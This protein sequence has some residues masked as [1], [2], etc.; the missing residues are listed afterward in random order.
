MTETRYSP[1]LAFSFLLLLLVVGGL[2]IQ[3]F[4]HVL[5]VNLSRTCLFIA[6]PFCL[7]I[8][9]G[10]CFPLDKRHVAVALILTLLLAV[11]GIASRNWYDF[12]A[13][14]MGYQQPTAEAI[15][16]GWNPF[17]P[18]PNML[19]QQIYPSG[20]GAA[21]ASVAA[22][23]GSIEAAKMLQIWWIVIAL[24]VLLA[25]LASYLGPLSREQEL[26]AALCVFSSI[27]FAQLLTHYVDALV[28]LSGVTFLGAL[29]MYGNWQRGN[30]MPCLAMAASILFLANAK[31]S[32]VY[33]AVAL[34]AT[35]VLFLWVGTKRA[36]WKLAI[37]LFA[38]GLVAVFFIGYRPYVTNFETYGIAMFPDNP[39]A[40][41]GNQR[42]SSF[43]PLPPPGR[44]FYSL[45][46][47][48]GGAPH[49]PAQLKL[50]WTIHTMEWKF[51]GDPDARTGGFGPLFA[52]GFLASFALF[53]YA[54]IR[55]QPAD[56][57]LVLLSML[58]LLSSALFPQSWWARY[59]PFAYCTP[60][61]LLLSISSADKGI[62]SGIY[63]LV[64][65]FGANSAIAAT[66]AYN[67]FHNNQAY[68]MTIAADLR[69]QPAGSVYL[70]PPVAN[71]R[72]YNDAYMPLMRRLK[73]QGVDSTLKVGDLCPHMK[74]M[75]SEYK[76]CY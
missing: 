22:L 61:L 54:M 23:Y 49:K 2:L 73:E 26:L 39:D 20:A 15:L 21:E 42:P 34:C 70:V 40:F 72:K 63:S 33:H 11:L 53:A 29:L 7:L 18:D 37:I 68:F 62:R 17:G 36:P 69:K 32:G 1:Y 12:T 44:F 5:N 25:G 64:I 13:D 31:L 58:C 43:D 57:G 27:V 3:T 8:T 60:F 50:P 4:G 48:S 71:Y 38:G 59:V 56:N 45:F 28:Y 66:S 74:E 35:A 41:I 16:N 65:L 76:L 6:L 47:I 14:G 75:Y 46:S 10:I 19:W 30:L 51:A 55:K 52:F 9:Y 67:L 24:P